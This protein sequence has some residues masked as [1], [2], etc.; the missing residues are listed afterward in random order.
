MYEPNCGIEK[1]MM[2]WGHDEYLY[3]VLL[4]N[5]VKFPKEALYMIRWDYI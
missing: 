3:R 1:L 4:H 5:N 2:S